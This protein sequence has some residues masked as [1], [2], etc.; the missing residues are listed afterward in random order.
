MGHLNKKYLMGQSR[1]RA[2][3][4]MGWSL[5]IRALSLGFNELENQPFSFQNFKPRN[6]CVLK[7]SAD[8][9]L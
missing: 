7:G 9:M 3:D 6:L 4:L 1:H 2:N 5:N 8:S